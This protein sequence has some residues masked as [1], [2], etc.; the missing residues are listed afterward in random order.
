MVYNEDMK[1]LLIIFVIVLIIGILNYFW[2]KEFAAAEKVMM[3]R[4]YSNSPI[5]SK[6]VNA[7]Y[8]FNIKYWYIGI[9][10]LF[11]IMV[12]AYFLNIL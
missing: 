10:M 3:M 4:R 7:Y 2:R 5:M 6:L 1:N 12:I 8:V 9:P 11:A